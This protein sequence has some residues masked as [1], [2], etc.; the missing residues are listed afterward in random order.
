MGYP[1][2]EDNQLVVEHLVHHPVVADADAAQAPQPAL[3]RIA[4]MRL[5]AETIDGVDDALTVL[6]GD[7]L[8][9][10]RC[11]ALDPN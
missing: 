1:D 5:L 4:R 9:L 10:S 6:A 7:S 8:Q 2:D 3:Q 11:A